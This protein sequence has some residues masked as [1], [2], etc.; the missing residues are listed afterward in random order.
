MHFK[1][2]VKGAKL[3][4]IAKGLAA[5]QAVFD[6]AGVTPY[7]AAGS[8]SKAG[9]FAASKAPS[10]TAILK[11]AAY[12]TRQTRPPRKRVARIGVAGASQRPPI[13]SSFSCQPQWRRGRRGVRVASQPTA[14]TPLESSGFAS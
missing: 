9:P 5:A 12:G 3:E 10:V 8:M 14:R 2:S 13:W 6:Q 11:S 7:E 4:E 1:I